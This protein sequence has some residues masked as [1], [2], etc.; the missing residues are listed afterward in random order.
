[1]QESSALL[2]LVLGLLLERGA[3]DVAEAGARVGGA[4][5]G[6]RLLLLLDLARLDRERELAR[7]LV[8]RRYLGVDLLADGEAVG[9]L[10][11]AVARQVRLADEAGDTV[12]DRDLDAALGDRRDGASD[13]IALLE[14]G[15]A[16]LVGIAR[17]LLDAEADAL[18]LDID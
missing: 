8:D 7:C 17:Q 14:L 9:A 5:L 18:L 10:L 6:H 12:A 13:D 15:D 3:E 1:M 16:L 2:V 4:V 11:A